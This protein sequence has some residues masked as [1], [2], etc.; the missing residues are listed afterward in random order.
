M[1]IW[2]NVNFY[3]Q[4]AVDW[5]LP[6]CISMWRDAVWLAI[7]TVCSTVLCPT[8]YPQL[9]ALP[10]LR[11]PVPGSPLFCRALAG[12]ISTLSWQSRGYMNFKELGGALVHDFFWGS[13]FC[14][15]R[16]QFLSTAAGS[17]K[18]GDDISDVSVC[19][20]V[21]LLFDLQCELENTRMVSISQYLNQTVDGSL[22]HFENFP[23]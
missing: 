3:G 18:N 17:I 15:T 5:R 1:A 7:V 4:T 11:S 10:P 2:V 20:C 13:G 21:S 16:Q 23:L 12:Q 8:P 6:L 22:W 9:T 19:L 14:N